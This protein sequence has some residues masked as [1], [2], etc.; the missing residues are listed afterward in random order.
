[1]DALIGA[2]FSSTM[3]K[4][5]ASPRGLYHPPAP[6][7]DDAAW[8]RLNSIVP[9]YYR[10][11]CLQGP[12]VPEGGYEG[13]GTG[14]PILVSNTDVSEDVAYN[15]TKAMYVHFDDYKD[16]APGANGWAWERQKLESSFMPFHEG[17][18]RY[19]KE[20]GKWSD[21]AEANQQ[22]NLKRQE[23]L[24]KAWKEFTADAPSDDEDFKNGWA[25]ARAS[26][27]EAAGMIAVFQNW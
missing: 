26:A 20:A 8:D 23:I 7:A 3:L 19:Y 22:K 12:G 16:S 2:T 25:K 17:S 18:V 24:Q 1:M 5:D 13:V 4:I 21:A 9:W 27:L 10:H 15:M 6:H 11:K 14:Y